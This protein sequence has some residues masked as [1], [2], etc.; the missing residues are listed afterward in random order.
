[1]GISGNCSLQ[2]RHRMMAVSWLSHVSAWWKL[3]KG[4]LLTRSCEVECSGENL[5]E[6]PPWGPGRTPREGVSSPFVA[7]KKME[8]PLLARIKYSEFLCFFFESFCSKPDL[9]KEPWT[10]LQFGLYF[11]FLGWCMCPPAYKI[12][13]QY[14]P[15]KCSECLGKI[16]TNKSLE[17]PLNAAILG[18]RPAPELMARVKESAL[19]LNFL[20]FVICFTAWHFKNTLFFLEF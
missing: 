15:P 12:M 2:N 4:I 1:M 9:S 11:T 14:V 13:Y 19:S 10:E 17:V 3:Y 8:I 20:A 18:L 16:Q 6:A 7:W 5:K